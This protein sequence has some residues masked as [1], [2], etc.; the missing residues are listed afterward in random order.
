MLKTGMNQTTQLTTTMTTKATL[1]YLGR[2]PKY[3]HPKIDGIV[4][5]TLH[6]MDEPVVADIG[7]KKTEL[8]KGT[9]IIVTS[10]G[11]GPS[12]R[13][14][15]GGKLQTGEQVSLPIE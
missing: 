14:S 3:H 13:K 8:P 12:G 1:S 9:C 6:V 10:G 7:G 11:I 15:W 2:L 4:Q 5:H